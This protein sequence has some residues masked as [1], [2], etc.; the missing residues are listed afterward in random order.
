MQDICFYSQLTPDLQESCG[1]SS[2]KYIFTYHYQGEIHALQQKGTTTLRL[3]DALDIWDVESEGL[4]IEKTVRIAYPKLLYGPD[5]IA[6]RD[7]EIGICIIWTNRK[8]TQTGIILPISDVTTAHG[9]VCKFDYSFQPGSIS[10]DLDLEVSMYIMHSASNIHQDEENLIND[11]GATLGTAEG[12]SVDF[13][14]RV[15]AF[16]IEEFPSDTDPLWWVEFSEWEDPRGTDMFTRDNVCLFLNPKYESCPVPSITDNSI[17][18]LDLLVDILAQ[19]YLMMFYRLSEDDRHAT[20]LGI[21]LA[22]NSICSVLHQLIEECNDMD[23]LHF[24]SPQMLLRSLQVNIRKKL[25][26]PENG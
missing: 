12:V 8:L 11:T 2:D 10:S 9:R 15:M 24:E 5:G 7:A 16:P 13:N 22:P 3:I 18:N 23:G 20:R 21:D 26:A 14:D 4:H 6:C 25:E 17:R 1:Y 19:T